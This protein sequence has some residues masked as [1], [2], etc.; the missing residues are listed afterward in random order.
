MTKRKH[1]PPKDAPPADSSQFLSRSRF[2][3]PVT[4]KCPC[5]GENPNCVHCNG[6]GRTSRQVELRSNRTLSLDHPSTE[7]FRSK[8]ERLF[9]IQISNELPYL[10]DA[11]L[12]QEDASQVL[13]FTYLRRVA[14]ALENTSTSKGLIWL[15]ELWGDG[16]LSSLASRL[17]GGGK[18]SEDIRILA[19]A[20]RSC[21]DIVKKA[22]RAKSKAT[23][24][25]Q[26]QPRRVVGRDSQLLR[27][28]HCGTMIYNQD[29][30]NMLFH[31]GL[32]AQPKRVKP[33]KPE[34]Q[35]PAIKPLGVAPAPAARV[36]AKAKP[37]KSAPI[38]KVR[39]SPTSTNVKDVEKGRADT[40]PVERDMDAR[41]TWGGRFRD[42]DGTFGSHPLHDRMDD[43]SNA[44]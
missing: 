23:G 12:R 3:D 43:E 34:A 37:R 41:R 39:T 36:P 15:P 40:G 31:R 16:D 5:E 4:F 30:H 20:A 27:C 28:P 8:R 11:Y 2:L 21:L 13:F 35:A 10:R 6:S 17:G 38:T 29:Q 42:T 9:E 22:A 7:P 1:R 26:E 14:L 25:G 33:P 24:A 32:R 44:G 18:I 19:K